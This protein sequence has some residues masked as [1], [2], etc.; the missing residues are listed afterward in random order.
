MLG[1]DFATYVKRILKRTDKDTE[2][3]EAAT[4]IVMDMRLKFSSEA[5]AYEAYTTLVDTVGEYK[6]LL[7]SD[8][9]H[10]VDNVRI[11]D[12]NDDTAYSPLKKISK[13]HY[14]ELYSQR[15]A[16]TT[17]NRDSGVPEHF[18][19]FGGELF[20]GP[21]VDRTTFR[22]HISYTKEAATAVTSATA[23]VPFTDYY[24]KTVR[25]GVLWQVYEGLEMYD[26]AEIWR[27]RYAEDLAFIV[28]N[29]EDNRSAFEP[30]QYAGV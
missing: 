17:T 23:S 26:E 7:P 13:A 6:I 14:D 21:P 22:L 27:R 8:F 20:I 29:D 2:I 24:R 9:G 16:S 15:L 11:I 4:D 18:C 19:I 12:T 3:Y 1:S 10:L 28:K 25:Y 5:Y 30:I